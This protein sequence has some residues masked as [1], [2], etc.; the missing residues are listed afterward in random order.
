MAEN[1]QLNPEE[2]E[3]YKR[4]IV[5][6]DIG[7]AGQLKLKASQVL[8]LGAG[9]LGAPIIAFLAGAGVG[10]LRMVDD[11]AVSLSNLHRQ[12]IHM[13]TSDGAAKVISAADFTHAL[14]PHVKTEPMQMRLDASNVDAALEGMTLAIDG[15]DNFAARRI[16]A[17][18]CERRAIPLISGAVH[19]FDGSL[20][21]F[22][23]HLVDKNGVQ[24]PRFNDLYPQDPK[25]GQLPSCAESGVIGPITGI[26]GTLIALEAIKMITGIGEPLIGRLMIYEGLAAQFS[27]MRYKRKK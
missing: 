3:R 15:S 8:V 22:A 14:N 20:S 27:E 12:I 11:D 13:T 9:G 24:N 1:T 2:I 25:E 10:L 26:I 4:H 7:G 19:R 21:V 17:N 16:L 23:P 5:L 18:A 6:P